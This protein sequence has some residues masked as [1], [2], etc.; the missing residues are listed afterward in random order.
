MLIASL[1]NGV[2]KYL[3]L[4][5]FKLIVNDV[6]FSCLTQFDPRNVTF[7]DAFMNFAKRKNTKEKKCD[8]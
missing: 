3:S 6:K 8:V 5:L 7:L 1:H 2:Q 4:L